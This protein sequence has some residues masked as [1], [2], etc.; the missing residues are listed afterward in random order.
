MTEPAP[1]MMSRGHHKIDQTLY[2]VTRLSHVVKRG[3]L[4]QRI[5]AATWSII[6]YT[7]IQLHLSFTMSMPGNMWLILLLASVYVLWVGYSVYQ[8]HQL[9]KEYDAKL[10][11][12]LN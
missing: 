1:D 4:K 3:N 6:I 8:I 11:N 12:I 9:D 7:I 10:K 5:Y 2:T